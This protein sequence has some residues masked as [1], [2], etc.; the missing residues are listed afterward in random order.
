MI[1]SNICTASETKVQDCAFFHEK[2]V[3]AELHK[4]MKGILW[5]SCL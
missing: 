4:L 1:T 3:Q 5:Y 2:F